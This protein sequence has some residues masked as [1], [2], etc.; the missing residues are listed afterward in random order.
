MKVILWYSTS[1]QWYLK[2]SRI[3]QIRGM[4]PVD[5]STTCDI[6]RFWKLWSY[7]LRW[8]GVF[9]LPWL[10]SLPGSGYLEDGHIA[11]SKV[12]VSRVRAHQHDLD[13]TK[14]RGKA[15]RWLRKKKEKRCAHMCIMK[16][17]MPWNMAIIGTNAYKRQD[18]NV[19]R[20]L[21]SMLP[22]G[23][24]WWE[25]FYLLLELSRNL[26]R[27]LQDLE[28]W[29]RHWDRASWTETTQWMNSF[30]RLPVQP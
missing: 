16:C 6:S 14:D 27:R 4:W 2:C 25:I 9:F 12:Q 28:E 5:E 3:W 24:V 8:G 7:S 29:L 10:C 11:R 30:E 1:N 26:Q 21:G 13:R 15:P 23:L 17:H 19:Q 22:Q 18:S 20:L